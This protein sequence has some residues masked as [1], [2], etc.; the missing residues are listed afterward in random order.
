MLTYAT[1]DRE[2]LPSK[3]MSMIK[4]LNAIFIRYVQRITKKRI[5]PERKVYINKARNK[6]KLLEYGEKE[7]LIYYW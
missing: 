5:S 6:C 4:L 2:Q 7:N 1:S 3:I